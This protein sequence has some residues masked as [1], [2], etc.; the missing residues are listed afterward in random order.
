MCGITGILS[1]NMVGRMHLVHLEEAT[2]VLETRGP[3]AHGTWFDEHVGLGH[4][5]LSI[6]DLSEQ[7]NQPFF[8]ET[9][10]YAIIYNGE[11]YNYQSLK[12]ELSAAG[13]SFRT[14]S[15]TEVILEAYK[16]YGTDSFSRFNGFF[17]LAIYDR[18]DRS[19]VLARD[20]F[21]IKPLYYFKD[22]DKFIF[23]S[24]LKALMALGIP[25][26]LDK[27]SLHQ[28]L[29]LTY[30]P[31]QYCMLQGTQK[32]GSGCF[33]TVKDGV[34]EESSYYTLQEEVE[35]QIDLTRAKDDI[36][37]LLYRSV[38]RRMV[39]DVPLGCFLSGGIDSSIVSTIAAELNPKLKTFSIGFTDNQYFDETQYANLVADKIGTEHTVFSLSNDDLLSHYT[40]VV[41][42]L[43]EPFADSSAIPFY[44]LS[45]LTRQQIT[46]ALSGDGADE[47]FS[48]YNKHEAWH[49]SG[50]GGAFNG[51]L[52]R[53]S[54]IW[55]VLPKSRSTFLT[56]KIRQ[57][58]K[59]SQLLNASEGE[60]YWL[61]ASF[62]QAKEVNR[63]LSADPG[64]LQSRQSDLL[65]DRKWE[66]L[67]EVLLADMKLVLRG[68]MLRKVDLM[69]MANGLE[70]RVPFLDHEVVDYAFRLRSDL[71]LHE[72]QRKR[73]LKE[74]F[75]HMLPEELYTR[76]K[77]GF[78]V[79]MLQWLRRELRGELQNVVFNREKIE[80][81]RIFNWREVK[82]IKR[83]LHS[84]DP[85]DSHIQAWSLYVFQKWYDKYLSN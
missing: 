76:P 72:G 66:D 85:G 26:E 39:S 29:Q 4:R 32:L 51:L 13:V 79:P 28:Y 65:T 53:L 10:R 56:D 43:S 60:K 6:I 30:V 47:V 74:A 18:Q 78:E 73:I 15:D 5:R 42:Y 48:G 31:D 23:G 54:P 33:A 55:S 8:D 9:E 40:D 3:D 44:I 70:V 83:R 11:V 62:I 58:H 1:F 14:T 38:E 81:Q 41:G 24:E 22:G 37:S 52:G 50:R 35:P 77:H 7:S 34:F 27:A 49:R 71:K 57:I 80:D 36:K 17:A 61:L 64:E 75:R 82:R 63:L 84:F 19:L 69:S 2:K 67:N 45:K 25:R 59:Y 12:R 21:G 68:D 16:H 20:R 46:V